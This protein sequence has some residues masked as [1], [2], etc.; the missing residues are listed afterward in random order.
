MKFLT[1]GIS[2]GFI[3]YNQAIKTKLHYTREDKCNCVFLNS[4]IKKI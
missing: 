1:P 3:C 4:Q 2:E